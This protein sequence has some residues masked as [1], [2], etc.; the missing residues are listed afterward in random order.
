VTDLVRY[1]A[2]CK[3]LAEAVSV[4]EVLLIHDE[5]RALAACARIAKN[6]DAEADAVVLRLRA[7]RRLDELR[8]AQKVTVGLNRGAA[9]GGKKTGSRGVLI[10]PR[11]DRPTL[12]SQGI[13]KNRSHACRSDTAPT[14]CLVRTNLVVVERREAH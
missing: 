8:Q 12:A 4:D 9:G 3:A 10:T 2:A 14:S 7:V 5:A 13:D 6:R 1:D 11:D